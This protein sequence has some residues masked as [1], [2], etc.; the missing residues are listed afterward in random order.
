MNIAIVLAG[1]T[2]TRLGSSIPK[3]YIR[4]RDKMIIT[5]CLEAF[6]KAAE[7]DG[8]WI[9]ADEPWIDD[10]ASEANRQVFGDDGSIV[11]DQI[12][13]YSAPGANR[14]LSIWNALVDIEAATGK[15]D[16]S[17]ANV[18]LSS[19][20]IMIHDAARPFLTTEM[21]STYFEALPGYDGVMPVLPM[22]DTVYMSEDGRAVSALI[23]RARVYAGQ[24]PE[25]YRYDMYK[26]A[27]EALLPDRIM[28]ING[29]T[30]VAVMAGMHIAMVPG[31]ES[32]FKI[33]TRADLERA[34]ERL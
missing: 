30:E 4:V 28:Q 20:N 16:S 25:I 17:L 24:A 6:A 9:V 18:D 14:Q 12:L 2:G 22:K 19:L 31:D 29:S 5:Y 7:I 32:N 8:I 3:Q 13:G 33:T 1:G 34:E 23:D 26:K 15:M 11:G 21:I 10:I 27:C